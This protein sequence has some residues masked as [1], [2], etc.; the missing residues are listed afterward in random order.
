M[1]AKSFISGCATTRLTDEERSFFQAERPWG[2]I[3]FARNCDTP[4][5]IKGLVSEYREAVGRENAPVLI[6]QEGGRVQRLRPPHWETYPSGAVLA[7][8]YDE[9]EDAGLEYARSVARL[10][11]D[12][13]LSLGINVD[14]L[15]VLDVPQPGSHEIISDRA[16][17]DTPDR[18]AVIGRVMSET[19]MQGGVLPVIKHL[20]GHGR[21]TLDSHEALPVVDAS[22][23]ELREVDF[24]PFKSLADMPL[25]MTAHIIYTAIDTEKSATQSAK[26]IEEIIRGEIGFDGALMSDD[27]SMKALGGSYV[28]RTRLSLEAGC[29]LALHCN[30]NMDEM[31]AVASASPELSGAAL[32]RAE[33]ALAHLGSA[34]P[35]D[36]QAALGDLE[37]L[38]A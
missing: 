28:D 27:L 30:G 29:D 32:E 35:F 11:A 2:L 38:C 34:A 19:L 22:L 6:D 14:C 24:A 7:R 17:G 8:A 20:P 1:S 31:K 26:L 36:R 33:R 4:E 12:D 9:N 23:E 3:L 21:A 5:Q 25:G 37:R 16:Y 13:L 10:L 18:I 15:P